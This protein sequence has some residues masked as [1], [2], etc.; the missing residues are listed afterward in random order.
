MDKDL[1]E[2]L[3]AMYNACDS[4]EKNPDYNVVKEANLN[5]NLRDLVNYDLCNFATYLTA[6]DGEI[7]F[8]GTKPLC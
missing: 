7:T 8:I 2:M 1:K 4:I 5:V 3:A 6:S